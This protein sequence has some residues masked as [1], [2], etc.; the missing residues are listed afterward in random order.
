MHFPVVVITEDIPDD[1]VI[2]KLIGPYDENKKGEPHIEY[3]YAEVKEYLRKICRPDGDYEE[4]MILNAL[5]DDDIETLQYYN[6]K[7]E[8]FYDIDEYGNAL[9]AGNPKAK[10]D[11]YRYGGRYEGMLE[12]KTDCQL[13]DFPEIDALA[14]FVLVTSEGEW[15]EPG[16]DAWW[17]G[18]LAFQE[19]DTDWRQE[20][21]RILK[22]YPETYRAVVLDCH[23]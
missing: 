22:E 6:R 21:S 12:G 23:I 17:L 9:S 14:P 15:I 20:F 4:T 19:K 11:Y 8:I 13:K 10:W 5:E 2:R 3:P 16:R 1:S 18:T 7:L